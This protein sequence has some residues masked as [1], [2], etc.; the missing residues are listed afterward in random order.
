MWRPHLGLRWNLRLLQ[1]KLRRVRDQ[2]GLVPISET[3]CLG[4]RFVYPSDSLI[5][6]Q[7]ASGGEWDSVLRPIISTLL[8]QDSPSICEV[9]SNIGASTL[10]LLAVKPNARVFAFEPSSR[11]CPIL[12]R[13]L[14]LAG[15]DGVVIYPVLLGRHAGIITLYNNATTASAAIEEYDGHELRRVQRVRMST[16]DSVFSSSERVDFIKIDTDGFEFEVLHGAERLIRRD[17]PVLFFEYASRL[18]KSPITD[19]TWLQQLGYQGLTCWSPRGTLVGITGD[20]GEA[21]A[22]SSDNSYVDILTCVSG[23]PSEARLAQLQLV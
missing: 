6:R 22:W 14:H 13:N 11:F 17:G 9:G 4:H 16:L 7:I 18:L 10:Q 21:A 15:F 1:Q 2:F 3:T 5:G 12:R 8:P 23:S 19:L 20:P